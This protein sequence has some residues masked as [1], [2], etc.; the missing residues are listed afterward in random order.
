[1]SA[2]ALAPLSLWV[3]YRYPDDFPDHYVVRRHSV[4]PG[5]LHQVQRRCELAESLEQ[6]RRKVPPGLTNLGRSRDDDPVIV[7]VWL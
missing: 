6:A 4:L 7:E 5:G 3:I 1:M 2:A